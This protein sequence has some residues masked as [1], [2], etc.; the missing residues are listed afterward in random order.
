VTLGGRR[1]SKAAIASSRVCFPCSSNLC[2]FLDIG[3]SS[4]VGALEEAQDFGAQRFGVWAA[5]WWAGMQDSFR[6]SSFGLLEVEFFL[7]LIRNGGYGS[8]RVI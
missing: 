6:R 8:E 3:Y 1:G 7:V 5:N 4:L 2:S